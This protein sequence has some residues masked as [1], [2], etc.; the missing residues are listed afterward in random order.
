MMPLCGYPVI[1]SLFVVLF[2]Y[3]VTKLL[4]FDSS[5]LSTRHVIG[6]APLINKTFLDK[7]YCMVITELL[8]RLFG[9]RDYH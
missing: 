8:H 6:S 7:C 4:L 2:F 1:S 5:M 9:D 3:C